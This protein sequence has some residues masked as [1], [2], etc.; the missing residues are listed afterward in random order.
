MQMID[1]MKKLQ[2][3][4]GRTPETDHAL[5][6]LSRMN[7][8]TNVAEGIE[9]KT[10]GD[11]AILAQILKLA[12]MANGVNSPDMSSAPGDMPG[13][14]MGGPDPFAS[15]NPLGGLDMPEPMGAPKGG[16]PA[17]IDTLD[18]G[19]EDD[20]EMD[21]LGPGVTPS[22]DSMKKSEEPKLPKFKP[23]F[24]A[25]E[26]AEGGSRP[27]T[28]SPHEVTKGIKAA[29]PSGNDLAKP[30]LTAPKVAGGDNPTHVAVSFD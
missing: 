1:V 30:K 29:V 12:G 22:P 25:K 7:A 3:I 24:G 17:P 10:T 8:P 9:I 21:V 18:A 2:E 14:L 11:D 26:A 15:D 5:D 28:N 6:N 27:Y 4:A 19:P 16:L 13:G 23:D 20:M